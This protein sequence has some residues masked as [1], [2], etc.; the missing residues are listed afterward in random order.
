MRSLR[1][2]DPELTGF[3]LPPHDAPRALWEGAFVRL[4]SVDLEL[5]QIERGFI[6]AYSTPTARQ[7]GAP[8]IVALRVWCEAEGLVPADVAAEAILVRWVLVADAAFNG[9]D[10]YGG[11]PP[12]AAHALCELRVEDD[13]LQFVGSGPSRT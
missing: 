12:Y 6:H 2:P 10:V 11:D 9:V 7:Y 5:S 4:N 13:V 3:Q 8:D 1:E